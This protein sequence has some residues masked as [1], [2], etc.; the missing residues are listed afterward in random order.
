MLIVDYGA[1][2]DNASAIVVDYGVVSFLYSV[3]K[4]RNLYNPQRE[5]GVVTAR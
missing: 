3:L 4:G 2:I 5:L 1:G